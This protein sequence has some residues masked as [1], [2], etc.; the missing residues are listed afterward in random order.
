MSFGSKNR[1]MGVART[2][3]SIISNGLLFFVNWG[4]RESRRRTGMERK[5]KTQKGIV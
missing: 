3:I 5:M 1:A 4:R 2:R